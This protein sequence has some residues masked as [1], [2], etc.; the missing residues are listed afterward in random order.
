MLKSIVST[1]VAA[2]A[3]RI[4]WRSEPR[5][6]SVVLVTVNVAARVGAGGS[7]KTPVRATT[8]AMDATIARV[9]DR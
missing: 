9:T 3:S 4:A 5:P 8:A 2:L 1:P 7:V 6:E